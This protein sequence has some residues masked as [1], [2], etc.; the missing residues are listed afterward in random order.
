MSTFPRLAL[1]LMLVS[2]LA[3][4]GMSASLI[5]SGD[6][7]TESDV[8]RMSILAGVYLAGHGL[9]LYHTRR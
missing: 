6:I 9:F 3:I 7:V 5:I 2:I 8:Y 4:I 1:A